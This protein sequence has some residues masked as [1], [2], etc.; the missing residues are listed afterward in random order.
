MPCVN[1][2]PEHDP[3]A[4]IFAAGV[5]RAWAELLSPPTLAFW[6]LLCLGLFQCVG[7]WSAVGVASDAVLICC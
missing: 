5:S 1:E 3:A 6:A 4:E 7:G 2:D